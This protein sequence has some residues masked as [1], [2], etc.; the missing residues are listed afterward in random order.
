M[1]RVTR[2]LSLSTTLILLYLTGI[3]NA[4]NITQGPFTNLMND[5]ETNSSTLKLKSK[6]EENNLIHL[7]T[8]INSENETEIFPNLSESRSNIKKIISPMKD[9][10][11]NALEHS[12]LSNDPHEGIINVDI[13]SILSKVIRRTHDGPV[14]LPHNDYGPPNVP[15]N[16][17]ESGK[18]PRIIYDMSDTTPPTQETFHPTPSFSYSLPVSQTANFNNQ[19]SYGNRNK[20]NLPTKINYGILNASYGVPSKNYGL[21]HAPQQVYGSPHNSYLSTMQPQQGH[22]SSQWSGFALP[23][24]PQLPSLPSF[25]F[26]FPFA[27]K[28][29]AFTIAKIIL[30]LVIFKMIVK[31]IAVLCL[32]L[33]IPKL[34]MK[35]IDNHEAEEDNDE[36]RRLMTHHFTTEQLNNLTSMVLHSIEMYQSTNDVT[37]NDEEK[38]TSVGC[39]M[40]SFLRSNET[41]NDYRE[42]FSNYINEENNI[43]SLLGKKSPT[44]II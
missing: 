25:D 22:G 7:S 30:K 19:V 20:Y 6:S 40:R 10:Y 24:L 5:I 32:L 23:D 12:H 17:G 11:L 27:L 2:K 31:F 37:F 41:W 26:L 29:N 4:L 1:M 34:E 3:V 21:P 28:F 33:F 8:N 15:N 44:K 9:S 38:C 39:Q 14:Y 42:L 35:K 16:P 18:N 43:I 36:G 13:K